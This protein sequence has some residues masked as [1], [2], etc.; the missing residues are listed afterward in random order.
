MTREEA[1]KELESFNTTKSIKK[2]KHGPESYSKS[3]DLVEYSKVEYLIN[4]IYN[5]YD[6][7]YDELFM[8]AIDV[9]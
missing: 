7:E 5:D 1:I 9:I 2:E 6:K 4:K 8:N 3:Y